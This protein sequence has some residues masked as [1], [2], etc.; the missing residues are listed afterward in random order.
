MWIKPGNLRIG[1]NI[2]ASRW[3]AN[4]SRAGADADWHFGIYGT[5]ASNLK[6]RLDTASNNAGGGLS[7]TLAFPTVSANKWYHVGFTIDPANNNTATLFIN[8]VADGSAAGVTHTDSATA[9][10]HVGDVGESTSFAGLISRVRIYGASLTASQMVQN[11]NND[12]TAYGIAPANPSAPTISGTP[13]VG[14]AL[15]ANAGTWTGDSGATTT[16]KW[17]TST[18]GS[19]WTDISGATAATYT[20]VAADATNF[21]R[22]IVTKTTSAGTASG[23][24][25]STA[26]VQT[27]TGASIISGGK[28]TGLTSTVPND[29]GLY[30]VTLATNNLSAT[31]TLGTTTGLTVITGYASTASYMATTISSA[32]PIISFRGTGTAINTAL[33]NVTYT[34]VAK[35]VDVVKLYYASASATA[36]DT[37]NYIPIYDN[38]QLTFHYYTFK[39]HATTKDRAGMEAALVG[40]TTTDEVEAPGPWYLV[41]PRYQVEWERIKVINGQNPSYMGA[42][43]DAGSAN[44]Y[45]PANTDG[46]STATIFGTQSGTT[47]T[48]TS[49]IYNGTNTT[50]PYHSGEPNGGTTSG[51]SGYFYIVNS[52][53]GWDDVPL[54]TSVL[55]FTMETYGTAPFNATASGSLAQT[56]SVVANS[57]DGPTGLTVEATGTTGLAVSWN[58][59]S[60]NLTGVTLANYRVEYS[61]S[62][63]F[64]T[65]S[66][67]LGQPSP[68]AALIPGLTANTTYYVRVL[69]VSATGGVPWGA[70]SSVVT[71]TTKSAATTI[72]VVSTGGGV[73][74]TD[75]TLSGGQFYVKSGSSVNINAS[76]I[77]TALNT[78]NAVLAADV[79][80][81]NAPITWASSRYLTLGTSATSTV[82]INK[83]ITASVNGAQLLISPTSYT[84]DVKN[85]ASIQFTGSGTQYLNIGGVAYT[86]IKTEAQL[87]A[88]TAATN[89]ALAKPLVLATTYTTSPMALSYTGK[90]DGLGNT[91]DGLKLN[92][93]SA[94]GSYGL[95]QNIS[96]GTVRNL[97]VTNVRINIPS[98]NSNF[99]VGALAAETNGATIDQVWTTGFINTAVGGT[100]NAVAVGGLIGNAKS[101][102]T[103]ITKSWS[104]VNI[105][106]ANS[107]S[108][109]YHAAGALVG[110][111][112]STLGQQSNGAGGT[113]TM[114]QVYSTGDLRILGSSTWWGKGGLLGLHYSTAWITITDAFYW[115]NFVTSDTAGIGGI[116]GVSSGGT[117]TVTNAYTVY[118]TNT[119]ASSGAFTAT[120]VQNGQTAGAAVT[121]QTGANWVTDSTNGTYLVNVAKPYKNIYYQVVAPSD[122]SYQ[123]IRTQLVDGASQVQDL[124]SLNLTTTGTSVYSV[125]SS[126]ARGTYDVSYV[127]G[128]TLGGSASGLYNVSVWPFTTSVTISRLLQT[129]TWNPSTSIAFGTGSFTPSASATSSVGATIS[130]AVT[131]QGTTGCSVNS[132]TG[133]VT[134]TSAGNC[135]VTATA[136][137]T[138]DY[139]SATKA[140]TYVI[141][142]AAAAPSVTAV[143]ANTT[144][145]ALSWTTPT[146]NA[147]TSLTG[148]QITYSTSSSMTSPTT[149]TT[150]STSTSKV[151]D[152]LTAGTTYYFQVRAVNGSTWSGSANATPVSAAPKSTSTTFNIV[153]SGGGTLGTDYKISNSVVYSSSSSVNINVADL[154]AELFTGNLTLAA[155]TINVNAD[156]SWAS[157][158]T[159]TLGYLSSNSVNVNAQIT[160]SGA[161][162]GLVIVPSTYALDVKSSDEIVLSGA[163]TTLSIGGN[164]YTLIRN[165]AALATVGTIGFYALAKPLTLTSAYTASPINQTFT[166]TLDGLGNTIDRLNLTT[167]TTSGSYGFIKT[168]GGGAS[169]RNLGVTNQNLRLSSSTGLI[170]GLAGSTTGATI[171]QVWTTGFIRTVNSMTSVSL[172]GI[173]GNATSGSLSI[174]KSWS[175]V[176]IDSSSTGTG[177]SIEQGGIV[178]GDESVV[179]QPSGNAGGVISLNQVYSTGTLKWVSTTHRGIGGLVGLHYN[180]TAGTMTITDSFSWANFTASSPTGNRGGL[181]GVGAGSATSITN[182]YQ[183]TDTACYGYL[184]P[185]TMSSPSCPA[186]VVVAGATMT[187][188]TGSNWSSSGAST[189]V[190]LASPKKPLFVQVL[191][192]TDGSYGTISHQIVDASGTV[193]S[194]ANLTALGLSVSGSALYSITSS[195]AISATPYSVYYVSGLTLTGSNASMYELQPWRDTTS[196]TI[197]KL[198]QSISF[199]STAPTTA[200]VGTTYTPA[201]TSTSGGAVTFTIDS[202]SASVC[203]IS[204]GVITFSALGNCVI[205]ANQAGSASYL[206]APQ[207]QQTAIVTLKGDQTITFTSSSPT[208]AKV[209]GVTYA[210]AGTSTSGGTPAFT[211]AAAAASI[212]SI[213]GGVVSFIGVGNCIVN[214]NQT[215]NSNWNAAT[216]SSQTFSV[217]KG[218]QAITFSSTAPTDAVVNGATYTVTATKTAG[219]SNSVAFTIDSTTSAICTIA[220]GIVSFTA[221]GTCKVN[222][223]LDGD[224]KYEAASQ[225]QQ[226]IAVAKGTQ[227]LAFTSSAPNAAKVGAPS[228]TVTATGGSS[229]SPIVLSVD[230]SA[231]SK[232]SV[233]GM[234]VTYLAVGDCVLNLNQAADSNFNAATQIQQTVTITADGRCPNGVVSGNYC[235]MR[236]N[237]SGSWTVPAGVTAIDLLVVGGGGAG[238]GGAAGNISGGGGGGGEVIE[239][240]GRL[241]TPGTVLTTNVGAGGIG[242]G[243]LQAATASTAGSA[244]SVTGNGFEA[245]TSRGGGQGAT[246]NTV[247]STHVPAGTGSAVAGGGGSFAQT[248]T[249]GNSPVNG[250]VSDGGLGYHHASDA[251]L[252]A[253]G[254][255]GGAGGNGGAG[256]AS[257]PGNGGAGKSSTI[258]GTSLGGGGGGGKRYV[259]VSGGTATAGGGAGGLGVAGTAGTANTGGGG[260]GS[261]GSNA[262]AN[263]GSGVVVIRVS[264]QSQTV[265][266]TSTA[267]TGLVFGTSTTYTP[268]VSATASE[269]PAVVT[270]DASSSS[271]CEISSGAVSIIG[272]G[273]CTLNANQAGNGFYAPANQVQQSFT[274]SKQNQSISFTSTVPT[275]AKV[276]GSSYTPTATGG[277]S[278]NAVTFT[279]TGSCSIAGGV[280]SF[281][282]VGTCTV[283]ADQA[284]GTNHLAATQVTQAITVAKGVQVISFTSTAPVN[285]AVDGDTYTVTATGG[286]SGSAV[287]FSLDSASSSICSISGAV[288]SFTASGA[289]VVKA[290]QAGS[291]NYEAASEVTQTITVGKGTQIIQITSTAP[292]NAVV[293]GDTYTITKT[294]GASGNPVVL[295]LSSESAGICS[296]SGNVVSFDAVGD[297]VIK[298]NQFGNDNYTAAAEV[299]ETIHVGKG[300]QAISWTSTIP[301]SA[302]VGGTVYTPTATGGASANSVEFSIASASSAICKIQNGDVVFTAVG[303]C[304]VEAN[305]AGDDNYV[306]ATQATQTITV[307]KGSQTVAFTT[308]T[309][310]GVHVAGSTYTPA[311][312]GGNGSAAVVIEIASSSAS[313][314]SMTNGEV[315]WLAAGSCVIEISQAADDNY[316]A[317]TTQT[318]TILVAKG[319]QVV[320]WTVSAPNSV[321]V[322]GATFTPAA[323]GGSSGESV[324]YSIDSASS[325]VCTLA[326]GDIS[327]HGAGECVV[328]ANQAGND[329]W[330]AATEISMTIQVGK[331]SQEITWDTSAPTN[332]VVSGSTYTPAATG[333]ATGHAV[334]FRINLNAASVCSITSGVVRFIGVGTCLVEGNQ[335][336]DSNYESAPTVTQSF[337]VGKG[338][339]VILFSST[340][341]TNAVVGGAKY[342]PTALGGNTGNPV[343]FSIASSS[344][345]VCNLTAG[346]VSFLTPGDCVIEANQAGNTNF[347]AA[348]TATQTVTVAKGSQTIAF[349]STNTSAKVGGTTYAPVA[350]GGP[351]GQAVT[352]TIDATASSICSITNGVVSFTAVGN[353][354][355]NANQSG[356]ASYNAAPQVQQTIAVA[357]G[358]QVV[359]F[360]SEPP[361][362]AQVQ[363]LTYVP[364]ANGSASGIDVVF[365]VPA[366]A[367]VYCTISN[368][369][370]SFHA[371]GNCVLYADQP[372]NANWNAATRVSQI[373]D[374]T[375]GQQTVTITSTAPTNAKVAGASYVITSNSTG[376]S[377]AVTYSISE[378][379][380]DICAVTDGNVTFRAAGEC[381]VVASKDGDS[382]FNP[383]N[384]VTQT[385]SVAKGAQILAFIGTPASPKVDDTGYTP[386]VTPGA[387]TQAVRLST[388]DATACEVVGTKVVFHKAIDCTVFADQ[389][390]DAN[391]EAAVQTSLTFT[392]AKGNQGALISHAS[393]D[394]LTLGDGN[395]P[396]T[397][398]AVSGGSGTGAYG[399]A[400]NP[401]SSNIC[402]LADDVIT[403][404]AVGVCQIDIQRV[405]DDNYLD[406]VDTMTINVSSGN[407]APVSVTVSDT[408]PTYAPGLSLTMSLLGGAGDGAVWYETLTPHVC[409]TDGDSALNIL[410]AGTCTIVGHKDG[411]D[412]YLGTQDD[413]TFQIA[414]ATMTGVSIDVAHQLVYSSTTP[415]EESIVLGGILSEGAQT[416]TVTEGDCEIV[417]GKLIAH[418]AGSC[419]VRLNVDTDEN[420]EP[421]TQDQTFSV[422]KAAQSN[423]TAARQNDQPEQITFAGVNTTAWDV[424][425]GSGNG[426][427]SVSVS[428]TQICSA[429]IADAAVTVTGITAGNCE[430]TVTKAG[431]DNFNAATTTFSVAVVSLPAGPAS[432]SIAN[433]GTVVDGDMQVTVSWTAATQAAGTAAVSGFELQRLVGTTWTTVT[434]GIVSA[435]TTSITVGVPAWTKIQLRV[436]AISEL[437]PSDI[438]IRDWTNFTGTSGGDAPVDFPVP[439]ALQLISTN[440]AAVTSGELVT[441]TG[442]GFAEGV[443]TR[444]QLS[445]AAPV[446]SAGIGIRATTANTVTLP[447]TVISDTKLS[448]VLPK[449]TMPKGT[450]SLTTSVKVLST[451]GIQSQTV[452][453]NYIPKKLSQVLTVTGLPATKSRLSIASGA[454]TGTA[455][456][457]SGLALVTATPESVCTATIEAGAVA[458]TPI[459]RGTCSVAVSAPT[460]PGYTAAASKS[461]SYTITGASQTISFTNP[462]TKTWSAEPF[463]LDAVATLTPVFASKTASVCLVSGNQLTMLKAGTC[464]VSASQ[465]GS[466]TIE[467]ATAIGS[468]TQNFTIA[469]AT[470]T[471]GLTATVRDV[472]GGV[473]EVEHE[474][475]MVNTTIGLT[476]ANVLVYLGENPVDVPIRLN[477]AEG[478]IALTIDKA[479]AARCTAEP[480]TDDPTLA[481]IT[482][483]DLG[484]CKVTITL[485]ADD[486]WNASGERIVVWVNAT[487][488]PSGVNPAPTGFGDGQEAPSIYYDTTST[489]PDSDPAVLLSQTGESVTAALGGDLGMAYDAVTGKYSFRSKTLLVGSYKATMTS[490]AGTN[491]FVKNSTVTQCTKYS[492]G[493][494][495]KSI[496]VPV[497]LAVNECIT[498]LTVKKDPKLKKR[499]LRII[500]PGCQLNDAGKAAFQQQGVQN[501]VMKYLWIRQYPSTGLSYVKKGSAKI[502]YLKKVKRTIVLSVGR[503]GV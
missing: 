422:A 157:N 67:V 410:H 238:G 175:S 14:T 232:C 318:Q 469:K 248:P 235:L 274:V 335:N 102:I 171:T 139:A 406:A 367:Q 431:D 338:T 32:A 291:A 368:G 360:T 92:A 80:N 126:V 72:N 448:F 430:V 115:G 25:A 7:S 184:T 49:T 70:Y 79:V 240:L 160:V 451:D 163:S 236:F 113:I 376:G 158:Q 148:Y 452:P 380:T 383:A 101:G 42:K 28:L 377:N 265:S 170:G 50:L 212:C 18:D 252:Q 280:V 57:F 379:S 214:A 117:T 286:A 364:T 321:V 215:G 161:S 149:I 26:K 118:P 39:S 438:T 488:A 142:E 137:Q 374:V 122:A 156:L 482:V 491:W 400:V 444:V 357:K 423:L 88:A 388:A 226:T 355:I 146:V 241:V 4:T 192:N 89:Y 381:V 315:S 211:I 300:A 111:D 462:G 306:A 199:T 405:G 104:S 328:H 3:F 249:R 185:G 322:D 202:G 429:A 259:G 468:A 208:T 58:S 317:A 21:L 288:I 152:G 273:T 129:V 459:G 445:T 369:V 90:F 96:G 417:D 61:T 109:P 393:L 2:L 153:A 337:V 22:I 426:G 277:G 261:G 217:S 264:L 409:N 344:S 257:T 213:S 11:F 48:A 159:L 19:T 499:V 446:F 194:A 458:V 490:P 35:Q 281:T 472:L 407:Q 349:T 100:I 365:S 56:V 9:Q 180:S 205:N 74:G 73:A 107:T 12:A 447:A 386:T 413:L 390:G 392:V 5:T 284:G 477:R 98:Y 222:A 375:K 495:V 78:G 134:Y 263:G 168:L 166:G 45:W 296:I 436:A 433:T 64:A 132:S 267:P 253:G 173:V 224:S 411:T 493:K 389:S 46:Y 33:A 401:D 440:I 105:D 471:T 470:R 260:G 207:V 131:S 178:G 359:A 97:G 86:L 6:L 270:V 301:S 125:T 432:V 172:G 176:N 346:K 463:T 345:A 169:V 439:G 352:F 305:Q 464:T 325:A 38:G 285:A 324:V 8:G 186:A 116:I 66:Y 246:Y 341:P 467:P 443:T 44:W 425:G 268:T 20:P 93:A 227:V 387:G 106:T 29:A 362:N 290:N 51:R 183:T 247:N 209:A 140:V 278:G 312:V 218:V 85:G 427:L 167:S 190:N 1:W 399:W 68:T 123:T 75:Y 494:C 395:S 420:Y 141:G 10:L 147:N 466:A 441:L 27:A 363:G 65:L 54:T 220:S 255:G 133:V 348:S 271:V 294:G 84:L 87:V 485:P 314:C 198:A 492:K 404:V 229:T 203:S 497:T 230:S 237:S 127:S 313:I 384:P 24:S 164:A 478:T 197:S 135:Q 340:A 442:T 453:F 43:A 63:T 356:N 450:L 242:G 330:E 31:M 223:N 165:E 138:T 456:A 204:A 120:N 71:F 53:L 394:N 498:T 428:N 225:I 187:G 114:N 307:G 336:G 250:G 378:L 276:S 62:S 412:T 486:R 287:T 474:L 358:T 397:V 419:G 244:S 403:G 41:T 373:F 339:Q 82:S 292:T 128:L 150:G 502:R 188:L 334:S 136:A 196:V 449:I 437:D 455:T 479:D 239:V 501:I 434:G 36:S 473:G 151:V 435:S 30:N 210:P 500:G 95:I 245:I 331:G 103:N 421:F 295:T 266:F 59:V 476:V 272:A 174:S 283:K 121:Q 353:C 415:A 200:K 193:Q 297:C 487:S 483:N 347:N 34:S 112:V 298:A 332:A 37:K 382:Q 76:E 424:S 299:T 191:T 316:N 460:T 361:H 154:Q 23:T 143:A 303:S 189:L 398:I 269:S 162:G 370:V 262:G 144:S 329:N 17:Q 206:A 55:N 145:V 484:S 354:V 110:T 309:P 47:V 251:A 311:G 351:S 326:N 323:T 308:T 108:I 195:A 279:V 94:L 327:F 372:G 343:T 83:S 16:H 221:V 234:V 489:D 228:Y 181:V 293:D 385:F 465:P 99:I 319:H 371:V 155:D 40:L 396:S 91:L 69:G 13:R 475:N 304:V 77:Q 216:Q 243:L 119:W 391:Y 310:S 333:G 231:I 418:S 320:S 342:T 233:S 130:Y 457:T 416:L 179:G 414:K 454:V 503:P 480:G 52:T 219:T 350:N 481:F 402:T 289:C 461:Y 256:A 496:K 15:T 182:S 258:L 81:I 366:A 275:N 254:G 124:G 302:V 408:T 282:S 177:V 60:S 201:A